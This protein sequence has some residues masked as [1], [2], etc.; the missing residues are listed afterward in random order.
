V[1]GDGERQSNKSIEILL[2]PKKFQR[3]Y[4]QLGIF[5][6]NIVSELVLGL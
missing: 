5:Q 6:G 1:A 3:D 4:D 2:L